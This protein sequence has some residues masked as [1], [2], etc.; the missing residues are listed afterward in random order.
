[1]MT[2]LETDNSAARMGHVTWDTQNDWRN[3]HK[4][5]WGKM[6]GTG[7]LWISAIHSSESSSVTQCGWEEAQSQETTGSPGWIWAIGLRIPAAGASS[8]WT[9]HLLLMGSEG[10]KRRY[11][12]LLQAAPAFSQSTQQAEKFWRSVLCESGLLAPTNPTLHCPPY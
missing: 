1:M 3:R 11:G 9:D 10:M 2:F 8:G 5:Q 7:L 6:T 4:N 12:L